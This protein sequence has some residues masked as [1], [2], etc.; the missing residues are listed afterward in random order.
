[1]AEDAA[2]IAL[3]GNDLR[4]LPELVH[5]ARRTQRIVRQGVVLGGAVIAALVPLAMAGAIPFT[6]LVLVH[7]FSG[8]LIILNGLRAGRPTHFSTALP[9]ADEQGRE[10]AETVATSGPAKNEVGIV[11]GR[12]AAAAIA[13]VAIVVGLGGGLYHTVRVTNTNRYPLWVKAAQPVFSAFED[14]GYS[15]TNLGP[16]DGASPTYTIDCAG[17]ARAIETLVPKIPPP[18]PSQKMQELLSA[19]IAQMR[20]QFGPACQA[21]DKV[22]MTTAASEATSAR[23]R[24]VAV[25]IKKSGG[26][27][28]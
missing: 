28:H 17:A 22:A 9:P 20:R 5:H 18:P 26:H 2:D 27:A 3:M 19:Y 23:A 16:D 10:S 13:A 25:A 11:S 8:V 12:R 21:G 7:E 6:A 15:Y 4:R 1:V 24:L 14:I